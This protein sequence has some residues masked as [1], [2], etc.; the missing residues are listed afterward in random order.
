MSYLCAISGI[1]HH[2]VNEDYQACYCNENSVKEMFCLALFGSFCDGN[3]K[4][5]YF[6]TIYK[7]F[8]AAFSCSKLT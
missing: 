1:K 6:I 2:S 4:G 3:E 7:S 5:K 8:H